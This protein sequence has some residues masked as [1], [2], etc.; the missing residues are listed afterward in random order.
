MKKH[1]YI[2]LL[3]MISLTAFGQN[4]K[5]DSQHSRLGFTIEHMMISDV[6][7]IFKTFELNMTAQKPDFSDAVVELVVDINSIDTEVDAR[8]THL[9]SPD[10]FDVANYPKMIF[11]ST[12]ISK[13]GKDKYR[14]NGNLTMHN[15]TKVVTVMMSYRG[16]ILNSNTK[17]NTA[18]FKITGKINRTDFNIA[19]AAP[20]SILGNEVQ[21]IADAELQQE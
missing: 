17:K 3:M 19:A 4:W 11:K 5:S 14:L 15:V 8:D 20:T 12:S 13:V 7:G 6:S 18:G 2:I 16:T 1:S 10:F 21:I 9:R